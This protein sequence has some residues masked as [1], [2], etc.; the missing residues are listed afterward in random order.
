MRK[1]ALWFIFVF[2][3]SN[4]VYC[5]KITA[6]NNS[7]IDYKNI[8]II[9]LPKNF[10][11]AYGRYYL[12]R[13]LPHDRVTKEVPETYLNFPCSNQ[14]LQL[15]NKPNLDLQIIA[16]PISVKAGIES[17]LQTFS[18]NSI[19]EYP[20]INTAKDI[21]GYGLAMPNLTIVINNNGFSINFYPLIIKEFSDSNNI[22]HFKE[23]GKH[24]KQKLEKFIEDHVYLNDLTLEKKIRKAELNPKKAKLAAA[25]ELIGLAHKDP[26][27]ENCF[28][29]K[30]SQKEI[31]EFQTNYAHAAD[32]FKALLIERNLI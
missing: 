7:N 23:K 10:N 5:F 24:K 1:S 13:V 15:N 9:L 29:D 16:H 32:L 30:F 25:Y 14:P 20:A 19:L 31:Q 6:I 11:A 27:I 22:I 12:G 18:C 3:W 17:K 26:Q 2:I 28:L 21:Q 4:G 8:T